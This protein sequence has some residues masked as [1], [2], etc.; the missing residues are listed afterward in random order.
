VT[1]VGAGP[2]HEWIGDRPGRLHHLAFTTPRPEELAG[3]VPAGDRVVEVPAEAN[4]GVR[5]LVSPG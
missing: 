4:L 3:A 5:L 2:L 1:P